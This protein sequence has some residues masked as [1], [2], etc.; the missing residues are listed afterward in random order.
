MEQQQTYISKTL[1]KGSVTVTIRRPV[2]GEDERTKRKHQIEDNLG[3][4]LSDYLKRI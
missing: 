1:K 2:M 4:S 3:R